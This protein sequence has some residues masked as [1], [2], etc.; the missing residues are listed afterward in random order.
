MKRLAAQIAFGIL[1]IFAASTG[2]AQ[3]VEGVDYIA[4]SPPQPTNDPS[5]IVV[6]E[7]FSYQCPHC[8]AFFPALDE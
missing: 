4:V 7:F 1:T 6:T 2:P 8:F 5:R 3:P